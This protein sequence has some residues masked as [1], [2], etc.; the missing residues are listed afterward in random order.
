MAAEPG[1]AGST[2][3]IQAQTLAEGRSRAR[4]RQIV[5]MTNRVTSL[6]LSSL[7]RLVRGLLPLRRRKVVTLFSSGFF[8]GPERQSSRRDLQVIA[9][10][11]AR[12]GV[13]LYTIDA[14][15]LVA[16]P[17]IGDARVG[18]SYDITSNPGA[19]ERIEIRAVQASRGGPD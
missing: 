12:S 19:R 7:E 4:A 16:T 18:G 1:R 3:A 9:D 13:V 14:R 5:S 8:L 6:P 15:G 11:A 2:R 17:A 10:A